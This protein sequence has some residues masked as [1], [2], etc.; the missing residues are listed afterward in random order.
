MT[1]S[2]K[3]MT[4]AGTYGF[5][6]A[7]ASSDLVN[8]RGDV[9]EITDTRARLFLCDTRVFTV[10]EPARLRDLLRRLYAEPADSD[11]PELTLF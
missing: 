8:G 10:Y 2:A 4:I 7:R 9:L 5:R 11:P 3:Y 6:A 1:T